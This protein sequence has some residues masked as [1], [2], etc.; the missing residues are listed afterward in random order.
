MNDFKNAE[1]A[2][3]TLKGLGMQ[4]DNLWS[5]E[6]VQAHFECDDNKAMEVICKAMVDPNVM[7]AVNFAINYYADEMNLKT[8]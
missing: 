5:I 7:E 4:V 3:K 1:Q 8:V 6:D 2:K